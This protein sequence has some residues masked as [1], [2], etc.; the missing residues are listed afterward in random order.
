MPASQAEGVRDQLPGR[1]EAR[2]SP[3]LTDRPRTAEGSPLEPLKRKK[4]NLSDGNIL[5]RATEPKTQKKQ[6]K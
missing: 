6:K 1:D 3:P 2:S 4:T 5:K